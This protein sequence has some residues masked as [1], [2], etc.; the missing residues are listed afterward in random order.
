[1]IGGTRAAAL[2]FVIIR[3]NTIHSAVLRSAFNACDVRVASP[4]VAS[5]NRFAGQLHPSGMGDIDSFLE[6]AEVADVFP[7]T[8]RRRCHAKRIAV[9]GAGR[10][11]FCRRSAL[12]VCILSTTETI[13]E[14]KKA[15]GQSGAFSFIPARPEVWM[16][17]LHSSFEFR[18]HH[19]G[20]RAIHQRAALPPGRRGARG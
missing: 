1:M 20:T 10:P 4:S 17:I 2:G 6:H 9:V 12:D 13:K 11:V 19:A 5:N 18:S 8:N 16:R 15:P 7:S 14:S 3:A